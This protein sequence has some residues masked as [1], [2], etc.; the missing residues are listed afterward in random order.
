MF[1]ASF[2][3]KSWIMWVRYKVLVRLCFQK[4]DKML[5]ED[6]GYKFSVVPKGYH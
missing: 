5:L 6:Y 1:E 4:I 3:E 2:L